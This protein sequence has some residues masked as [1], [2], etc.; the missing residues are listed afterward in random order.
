[1]ALVLALALILTGCTAPAP[2][3]S[4]DLS[5][6]QVLAAVLESQE[7]GDEL[8]V[9]TGDE[10]QFYLTD[11]YGLTDGDYT[12]AAVADAPGMDA[13]EVAVIRLSDDADADGAREALEDYRESR[14]TDFFG[15]APDQADLVERGK[16]VLRD[17]W[18]AL[19][20]CPDPA[21]AQSALERCLDPSAPTAQL[22]PSPSAAPTSAP[23]DAPA[24]TETPSATVEPSPEPSPS[25]EPAPE[26]S[27][28]VTPEPTPAPTPSP[29]GS[30]TSTP[31]PTAAPSASATPE[32]TPEPTPSPSP[33]PSYFPFTQPDDVDMTI[34][35]TSA[36]LSAWETGDETGLSER[37]G[38]ILAR[39]KEAMDELTDDMTDFQK[40]V[41]LYHWLQREVTSDPAAFDPQ[42][43]GGQADSTNPYGA[44]VLGRAVCL[45]YATA[46]SLLLDMAGVE[47]L[48][49]SGAADR[50]R[51]CHAWNMV[52][53]EGEWYCVDI[54]W[55]NASS[56]ST[57]DALTRFR[58]KYFNVTSDFM[59]RTD[60]QWD[61]DAIPEATGARFAWDG[62]ADM[63]A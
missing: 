8:T 28:S 63:P 39:C 20:L 11:L 38:A 5:A 56:A 35:D 4:E 25:A 43:P 37:D 57:G 46:F 6:A 22:S 49:V 2:A 19:L 12:D 32:P 53:L 51:A 18:L 14:A 15:Y 23:S 44:L 45:G 29:S 31:A 36:I 47:S 34:Y 17:G 55:S 10:L 1:M 54:T 59:R 48:V 60:H 16:V 52:K 21:A 7:T 13:R 58:H 27:S 62:V 30:P 26:P 24:P 50:S 42:T 40:E 61:Y 41:A 33:K 9:L 3:P